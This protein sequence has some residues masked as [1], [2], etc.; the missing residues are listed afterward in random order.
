MVLAISFTFSD[1]DEKC[2]DQ[3]TRAQD[4]SSKICENNILFSSVQKC[5]TLDDLC[6]VIIMEANTVVLSVLHGHRLFVLVGIVPLLQE[7]KSC[8]ICIMNN[9]AS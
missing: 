9:F 2:I 8:K 7:V 4:V 6:T 5:K 1:I 3:V